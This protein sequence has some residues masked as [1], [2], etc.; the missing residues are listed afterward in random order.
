MLGSRADNTVNKYS[1][2]VRV[3]KGFCNTRGFRA[4]PAHSIHVSVYLSSLIDEGKTYGVISS[5]FYAIK[6]LHNINDHPDPTENA[7][8]KSVLECARRCNSRPGRHCN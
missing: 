7:I 2:Q 3:F 6:W 5:A 4:C 1:Q 8:V